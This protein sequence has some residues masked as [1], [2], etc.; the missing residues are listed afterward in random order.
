MLNEPAA[1]DATTENPRAPPMFGNEICVEGGIVNPV[2]APDVVLISSS[3]LFPAVRLK[4]YSDRAR[5]VESPL[6]N[7]TAFPDVVHVMVPLRAMG[8]PRY[9]SS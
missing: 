6:L 1:L 2:E 4:K 9:S 5:K 8:A 3:T 7:R